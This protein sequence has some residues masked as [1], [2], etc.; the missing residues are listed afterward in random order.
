MEGRRGPLGRGR[1]QE[2]VRA[3]YVRET[4][5]EDTEH[6]P[7]GQ[8]DPAGPPDDQLGPDDDTE[9]VMAE[10]E[11]A[12]GG[13]A[14]DPDEDAEIRLRPRGRYEL[15][16]RVHEEEEEE[17]EEDV[18]AQHRRDAGR[19][20]A[21]PRVIPLPY[22]RLADIH[23]GLVIDPQAAVGPRV[24]PGAGPRGAVPIAAAPQAPEVI[25]QLAQNQG[26]LP[27]VPGGAPARVAPGA[28]APVIHVMNQGRLPGVPVAVP[29]VAAGPIAVGIPFQ[30]DGGVGPPPRQEQPM[31]TLA[32]ETQSRMVELLEKQFVYLQDQAR[33]GEVKREKGFPRAGNPKVMTFDGTD[34]WQEYEAH[35]DMCAQYY[36]WTEADKVA[37]VCLGL[38]G[39]ARGVLLGLTEAQKADYDET[40]KV[41]KQHYCPEEKRFVYQAELKHR[42]LQPGEELSTLAREIRSKSRLAYPDANVATAE[43]LMTMFFCEGLEREMRK[44]VLQ[45]RPRTLS[46][47][48]AIAIQ[49]DSIMKTDDEP[50][51]K[52]QKTRQVTQEVSEPAAP[53]Q[54]EM[55]E[56]RRMMESL[57]QGNLT[58]K[59]QVD[60]LAAQARAADERRRAF[61]RKNKSDIECYNCGVRGH[62]SRECAQPRRARTDSQRMSPQAYPVQSALIPQ[63]QMIP[64]QQVPTA[65]QSSQQATA[66]MQSGAGGSASGN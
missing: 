15:P 27:G 38:R 30:D 19:Q 34:S 53:S 56:L 5:E 31:V 8:G 28:A 57:I 52:K 47:A 24:A 26:R 10:L 20:G 11:G 51:E 1:S 2:D 59:Q 9:E 6:V 40:V 48:L 33:E 65:P 21:V 7:P 60:A 66:L 22:Q 35:I 39:E 17:E 58:T 42:R 32:E 12:E 23:R 14:G 45:N 64:Q 50:I 41:I 25:V 29:I 16:P 55:S 13:E 49:L 54:G 43:S 36:K 4:D 61:P 46:D 3:Q 63:Q 62:Y 18:L 37:N 44:C